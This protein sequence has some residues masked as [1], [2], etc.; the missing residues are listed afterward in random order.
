MS[1]LEGAS[2][3]GFGFDLAEGLTPLRSLL[4]YGTLFA[5]VGDYDLEGAP[6]SWNKVVAVR[7]ALTEYPEVRYVWYLDQDALIMNPALRVEEHVMGA[8]RLEEAMIRDLP[9]VPPDSIIKTFA[10]LRA[11]DV[12]L[13]ISQDKA[14]MAVGSFVL[15]NGDWAR[16]FLDT[17]FDPLYRSYN[18]QKAELHTLVS[19]FVPRKYIHPSARAPILSPPPFQLT[20]LLPPL[21]DH[22]PLAAG[23]HGAVAPDDPLAGGGPAAAHAERVLAAG[24]RRAV[25]RGRPRR[26]LR[27]LPRQR[28]EELRPRGRQV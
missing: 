22:H 28:R 2:G 20:P 18:F 14:G 24:P 10:G 23:T 21:A 11:D 27:L 19:F 8:A 12:A 13:A 26:P 17:W 4:G 7:H 9:V 16:F 1:F 5:K 15:R 3:F 6:A 25:R